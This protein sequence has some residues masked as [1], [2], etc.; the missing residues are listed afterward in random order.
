MMPNASGTEAPALHRRRNPHIWSWILYLKDCSMHS[1]RIELLG[2]LV[3]WSSLLDSYETLDIQSF[4]GLCKCC[5]PASE[6][7]LAA[8][9]FLLADNPARLGLLKVSFGQ[10]T[11]GLADLACKGVTLG[12]LC[13]DGLFLHSLHRSHGFHRLH[14]FGHCE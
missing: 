7:G 9:G 12:E 3:E 5:L 13:R 14:C 4:A 6:V 2:L 11:C 1:L 8:C 10:S